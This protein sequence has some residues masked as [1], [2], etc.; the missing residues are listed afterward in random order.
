MRQ[1]YALSLCAITLLA[2]LFLA[3]EHIQDLSD[4]ARTY[5]TFHKL[6][7][8]IYSY[9][10]HG[11]AEPSSPH[12]EQL[13]PRIL[14][15]IFLQE[16]RNSTL[17]KYTPARQS[18]QNIHQDW[19]HMLWTDAN[20]TTFV[21][22]YYPHILPHY[23]T[24]RQTIQRTNILRYLL[25]HHFGGVYLDLDITCRVPLDSLT[26][27]PWITPA[28]H[29]AGINNAFILARSGHPFLDKVIAA[30]AGQDL[31]WGLPYVENMLSTGCMFVTNLWMEYA[32]H[33]REHAPE[34]KVYLLA[35][36]NGNL[37][38][39]MLRGAIVTPLFEHGGASSWHGWDAA[40]IVLVGKHYQAVAGVAIALVVAGVLALGVKLLRGYGRR[41]R[42]SLDE[43]E[44]ALSKVG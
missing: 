34:D 17:D 44:Q 40:T 14:H 42:R 33:E 24:Y 15:Q 31:N 11:Q 4:I 38:G 9:P 30:I 5:S 8:N 35:D 41:R 28:A 43:E 12:E 2:C 26:H 27:L 21:A 36:E 23:K 13:A 1:R 6:E 25:I 10:N 18:C 3:R 39:Q 16:G 19:E 32:R 22:D 29:P 7:R 37:E 20:A